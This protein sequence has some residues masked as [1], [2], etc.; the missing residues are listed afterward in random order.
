M[1]SKK[2]I[3]EVGDDDESLNI[4]VNEDFAKKYEEKKKREE[5][6]KCRSHLDLIS[7]ICK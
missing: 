4:K 6:S 1:P 5:L 2:S 7:Y 3:I